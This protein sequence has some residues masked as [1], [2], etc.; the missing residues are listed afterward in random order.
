M[1]KKEWEFA[2]MQA[3]QPIHQSPLAL[4]WAKNHNFLNPQS[5]KLTHIATIIMDIIYKIIIYLF[6]KIDLKNWIRKIR[7]KLMAKK[8]QNKDI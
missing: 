1:N 3:I 2:R 6:L 8:H 4:F 7:G 5:S